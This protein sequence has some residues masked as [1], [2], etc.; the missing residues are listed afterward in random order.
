MRSRTSPVKPGRR[1][2]PS[3]QDFDALFLVWL[4]GRSTEDLLNGA[5]S[6]T[7][8][9]AD[10]MG[11]YS[12]LAARP[13]APAELARWMAAPRT[14]VSSYVKRLRERGHVEQT[15]NPDDGRSYR[16][17]LT[18]EGRRA[19][20]RGLARVAPLRDRLADALA[21]DDEDVRRALSRLR[22]AIDGLR[23]DGPPG[24]DGGAPG[25]G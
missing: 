20:E 8:L 22:V 15:A 19:H 18:P 16:L 21:G 1:D 5:L 2:E 7:G 10:E 24:R 6:G 12:V 14:T 11:V 23:D 4:V 9:T 25:A 13:L 17:A 3:L